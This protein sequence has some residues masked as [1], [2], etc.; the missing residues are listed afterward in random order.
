[1]TAESSGIHPESATINS[2]LAHGIYKTGNLAI[3]SPIIFGPGNFIILVDGDLTINAKITVPVGSTAIFSVS[4]DIKVN[5]NL[6]EAATSDTPTIEGLYS[7]DRNFYTKNPNVDNDCT[8]IPDK[9]LNV[10]GTVVA[11]AGRSGGSFINKRDLCAGNTSNPSVSFIERPDFMLNY[12]SMV[13]QT[14][15]S[16]QE[17]A[18]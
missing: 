9:R 16:W 2:S 18:P 15:R 17:V 13:K 12:P 14:T 1:E 8:G 6:G 7:A 11:N 10:A 4:G 3:D 5:S